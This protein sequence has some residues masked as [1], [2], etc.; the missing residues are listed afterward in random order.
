MIN[1]EAI[2]GWIPAHS[3]EWYAQF[4]HQKG[5]YEYEWQSTVTEPNGET[6]FDK[7]V[8]DHSVGQRVVDINN[9]LVIKC[10]NN[11]SLQIIYQSC[12]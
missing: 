6:V 12:N 9:S 5:K 3:K 11:F 2:P 4:S 1:P 10:H 8:L 7:L